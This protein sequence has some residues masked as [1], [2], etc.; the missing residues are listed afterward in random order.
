MV[1][2][3]GAN[4]VPSIGSVPLGTTFHVVGTAPIQYSTV[5]P[6]RSPDDGLKVACFAVGLLTAGAFAGARDGSAN[7]RIAAAAASVSPVSASFPARPRSLIAGTD[8]RSLT[9]PK[10]PR[11][12]SEGDDRGRATGTWRRES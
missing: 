3:A 1:V 12:E 8:S 9:T 6:T 2:L 7:V 11:V 4:V 10:P 5:C